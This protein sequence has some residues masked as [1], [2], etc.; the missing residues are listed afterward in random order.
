MIIRFGYVSHAL[1]LWDCSPAKTLTFT[2]WQKLDKEERKAQ[3]LHVTRQNLEHTLRMIHYNIAHE[4]YLYRFSSSIVPLATH[5]EV[6]WDYRT[7]FKELFTEIGQLVKKHKLRTSFHPN[8]FTL[9]TSDKKHITENAV[10][11]M[12][13]HFDMLD[14]MG[15]SDEGIINIHVGGAYGNKQKATERFHENIKKLPSRIKK[16]MTLENDDKT[17]TT[18]ETLAVCEK[19]NITLLFDYHHYMANH[20]EDEKIEELLP[21]VFKTW[22]WVN[23]RPKIHVS[24][25]KSEKEFRSHADNVD[26]QFLMPLL[27]YLKELNMDI[28][29]MI[30]AKQKDRA[31]LKLCEDIA[32]IRGVK[33]TGGAT[34]EW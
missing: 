18:T 21:K 5:P 2:R 19:E 31:A 23:L 9:F 1:S 32:K 24:S 29:F 22:D 26:V 27:T 20:E 11:D 25:P 33:R 34:I 30:E 4:I 3:L 6:M 28:D 16:R 17:Y 14:A 7:P 8:Q 15:L 13:Y 12:N 10:G